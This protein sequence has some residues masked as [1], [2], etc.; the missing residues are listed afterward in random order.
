MRQPAKPEHT[1]K[2]TSKR[3]TFHVHLLVPRWT[4]PTPP[5]TLV[6]RK[7]VS[8]CNRNGRLT[9]RSPLGPN[10]NCQFRQGHYLALLGL[11]GF[12]SAF[13]FQ[14]TQDNTMALQGCL[15]KVA[16][17]APARVSVCVQWRVLSTGCTYAKSQTSSL[18][19]CLSIFHQNNMTQGQGGHQTTKA[20]AM[21]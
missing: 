18:G 12:A 17:N 20:P 13:P 14:I 5:P 16:S 15:Q 9:L 7:G 8:A 3:Q 1:S 6:L 2:Q 11:H 10:I 4:T 21:A 19:H